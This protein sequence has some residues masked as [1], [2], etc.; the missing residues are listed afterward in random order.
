MQRH[1][2]VKAKNLNA[3]QRLEG[4]AFCSS[5]SAEM[6]W[7]QIF[8]TACRK[9]ELASDGCSPAGAEHSSD[10]FR[11]RAFSACA[12]YLWGQP[13]HLYFYYCKVKENPEFSE[14]VLL[15]C[16]AAM[17]LNFGAKRSSWRAHANVCILSDW[18]IVFAWTQTSVK[19]HDIWKWLLQD[20]L[21]SA[22]KTSD[23]P[24]IL[25]AKTSTSFVNIKQNNGVCTNA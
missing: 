17:E 21:I 3:I 11:T 4:F 12:A 7:H 16:G 19:G 2:T 22:L 10:R 15:M 9:S 8:L 20:R 13:H 6:K 18:E 5:N 23:S 24:A 25:N 14:F 1:K